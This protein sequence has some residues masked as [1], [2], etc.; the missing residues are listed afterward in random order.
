[1][2]LSIFHYF[3]FKKVRSRSEVSPFYRVRKASEHKKNLRVG[4][5]S[6]PEKA[7]S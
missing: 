2:G 7:G 1:M 3:L 6:K 5:S 4:N